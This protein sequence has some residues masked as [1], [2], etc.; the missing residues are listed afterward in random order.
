M[1]EREMYCVTC[2]G[3]MLF[4]VPP[5]EDGHGEDCPELVCT[6]CGGAV[7]VASFAVRVRRPEGVRAA[8]WRHHAA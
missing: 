4:E 5:C 3:E 7:L 1:R 6:G 8:A 2:E